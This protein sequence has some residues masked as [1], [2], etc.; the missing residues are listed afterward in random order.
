MVL[1][2][3]PGLY[4]LGFLRLEGIKPED[5]LG[6]GRVLIAALF[7]TFSISL[8]PGLFGASLGNVEAFIPVQAKGAALLRRRRASRRAGLDEEPI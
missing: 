5:H 8:L 4:L 2:A 7:L 1:F 6:V 3:L